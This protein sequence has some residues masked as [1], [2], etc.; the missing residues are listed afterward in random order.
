MPLSPPAER[1]PLHTRHVECHGYRRAD[2]LW[3][4]EGHMTDVKAYAFENDHR[5]RIE[6]G[7]PLHDMRLRL[8]LDDRFTILEAEAATDAAPYGICGSIAPA[9]Q[10]LVGLRVKAGFTRQVKERLGGVRGCTHLVELLGPMATTAFQTIYPILSRE[11]AAA[12]GK[13]AVSGPPSPPS[14]GDRPP[15]LLNSCH[16]FASDGEIARRLWPAFY[17]GDHDAD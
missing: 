7:I 1:E 15:P 4:V 14:A 8:T 12:E 17:T 5:G 16:A 2:G 6:P 3:E 11:R 10:G 13:A 9:F